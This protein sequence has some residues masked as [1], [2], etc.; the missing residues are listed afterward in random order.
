MTLPNAQRQFLADVVARTIVGGLFALLSV[1][2]L[3]DFIQTQR[4]TG[5]LLLISESLVVVLTITPPREHR[6]SIDR[7]RYRDG[8]V[9]RGPRI[10]EDF[11][12]SGRPARPRDGRDL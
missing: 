6:R 4:V 2:L 3:T 10:S 12:W 1:N 11:E 5:L 8:H 7:R 9:A